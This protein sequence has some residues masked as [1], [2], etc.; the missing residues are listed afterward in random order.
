MRRCGAVA[1]E[2]ERPSPTAH[3]SHCAARGPGLQTPDLPSKPTPSVLGPDEG[4]RQSSE[5]LLRDGGTESQGRCPG[6]V[7]TV[8]T[9]FTDRS[10]APRAPRTTDSFLTDA[11]PS[12]SA[13]Q[14]LHQLRLLPHP[15]AKALFTL[16]TLFPRPGERTH[17]QAPH[18]PS[19]SASNPLSKLSLNCRSSSPAQH[20]T[21]VQAT[22]LRLLSRPN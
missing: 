22:P 3:A 12:S 11:R 9:H 1:Q 14:T 2:E 21:A 15:G 7:P 18:L 20:S 8:A 5:S 6:P 19:V 16:F 4:C 17:S 10:P 13:P